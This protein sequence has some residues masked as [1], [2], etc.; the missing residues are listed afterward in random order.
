MTSEASPEV[1]FKARCDI[2]F[3]LFP[4][5]AF[6]ILNKNISIQNATH[7]IT[8]FTLVQRNEPWIGLD[9][10][11]VGIYGPQNACVNGKWQLSRTRCSFM[12]SIY[13]YGV[14]LCSPKRPLISMNALQKKES[15]HMGTDLELKTDSLFSFLSFL[16]KLDIVFFYS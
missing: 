6:L 13:V 15:D 12:N 14:F 10:S 4:A 1:Q 11:N 9:S 2:P 8:F 3:Q 16:F 5:H 7:S